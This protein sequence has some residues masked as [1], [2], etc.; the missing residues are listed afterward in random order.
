M[1]VSGIDYARELAN[2]SRATAKVIFNASGA[3]V[4]PAS[5]QHRDQK[6]V[7]VSYEDD[8]KGN[9]LAAMISKRQMEI[10]FHRNFSDAQVESVVSSLLQHPELSFIRE[11]RV[12]YQGREL[13]LSPNKS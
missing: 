5:E 6:T 4:F 1:N 7:G 10:R 8:Y 9:A 13:S 2:G 11:Y 3:I 12:T